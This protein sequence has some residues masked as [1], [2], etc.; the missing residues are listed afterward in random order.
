MEQ[1]VSGN[2]VPT[3][4]VLLVRSEGVFDVTADAL[5]DVVDR[6]KRGDP[7]LPKEIV[8]EAVNYR[9]AFERVMKE[10]E[11]VDKLRN[12]VAGAVGRRALD[13]DAARA[14]IGRRMA[15]LRNGRPG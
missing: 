2:E 10:R 5:A 3:E 9:V 6:L 4:D 1:E 14:E 13:L 7:A 12:D 15:C 11:N 8:A